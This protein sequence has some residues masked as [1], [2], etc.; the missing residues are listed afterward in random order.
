MRSDGAQTVLRTLLI[1]DLADSTFQLGQMGDRSFAALVQLHDRLA[2]DLLQRHGGQEIDKTDGFL[3]LFER[4]L[5]AVLYALDYHEALRALG[6]DEGCVIEGRVGIHLGEVVLREN[7]PADVARGAK[8]IEVEGLAKPTAARLMSLAGGGQ[9]LLTRAAFIL[10]RRAAVDAGETTDFRWLAHGAYCF[11]G[12]AQPVGVFEVGRVGH[13]PLSP[14]ADSAKA[15]RATE[16]PIVTDWRPVPGGDIPHRPHW[17]VEEKLGEGGFGEVWLAR[18][19]KTRDRRVFKFCYDEERLPN[20]QREITLFRLLKDELGERRDIVRIL[21]WNFERAPYFVE[22]EYTTAG[23]LPQWLE[24][25]GGCEQ[26]PLATR[27]EIVAQVATAL[28]AAHSV[29]ILHKDVK[30]SNVLMHVDLDGQVQARLADFGIGRVVE[31]ERLAA[32]GIT[33]LG[34]AAT[35]EESRGSSAAGTRLYMA[36]EV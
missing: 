29:G 34:M 8:P 28:A 2:R 21:D 5:S 25:Q 14:P 36:P 20:L 3:L 30:P 12:V 19:Y 6:V 24:A 7:P 35:A 22:S 27:I 23:D 10:A 17:L 16:Q 26:V 15:R 32:A 4:P 9:T 11:R 18:H 33:A 31:R 13:A 1:S